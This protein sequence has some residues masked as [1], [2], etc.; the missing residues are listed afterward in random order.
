[1]MQGMGERGELSVAAETTALALAAGVAMFDPGAGVIIGVA[2]PAMTRL[3]VR[4]INEVLRVA[5]DESEMTPEELCA[6]LTSTDDRTRLLIRTLDV[7]RL[8]VHD[9]KLRIL[10]RCLANGAHDGADIDLEEVLVSAVAALE[11]SHMRLLRV[12]AEPGPDGDKFWTL[13][14]PVTVDGYL[15][16]DVCANLMGRLVAQGVVNIEGGSFAEDDG[17]GTESYYVTTLGDL[18]L[19]RAGEAADIP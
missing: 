13:R 14:G 10:G 15:T 11:T 3:I 9:D 19:K 18:L 4:S 6:A 1:M 8:A 16:A 12:L 17:G 2:V 5:T 7:A